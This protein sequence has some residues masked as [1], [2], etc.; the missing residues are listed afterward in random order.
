MRAYTEHVER[1]AVQT[2]VEQRLGREPGIVA[3]WLFG[4]VARGTSY[5][6][7]AELA[8]SL[9]RRVQVVVM[10]TAPADLVHR[11]LRDGQLLLDRD[12][13]RRI[14]FEVQSRNVYFDMLPIWRRYRRS[15]GG[16]PCTSDLE[17]FVAAIRTRL[18]P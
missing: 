2:I 6:L 10:N 14:A 1:A 9:G 12:R 17:A 4:S 11:V 7:E 5:G 3:V 18:V 13:S 15:E 8:E 16:A